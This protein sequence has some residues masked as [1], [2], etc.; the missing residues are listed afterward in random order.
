MNV[1]VIAEKATILV[2]D[3]KPYNLALMSGLF[4]EDYQVKIATCGEKALKIARSDSPP[5]LILLDIMMPVM[6]G[7][8]VCR[9]LK[10]DP[11]T[12]DI[13]VIFLTAK[14]ADEDEERGLVLGAID[15]I[16]KP[17]SLPIVM[18]RVKA[19]LTLKAASDLLRAQ[20][21]WNTAEQLAY[22]L[23][24]VSGHV[25]VSGLLELAEKIEIA[26]KARAD[27]QTVD[28]ENLIGQL[29]RKLPDELDQTAPRFDPEKLRAACAQ[30]EFLLIENDA[31]AIDVLDANAELF[32]AAFPKQ[33]H[34]IDNSI[35]SFDFGKAL[36][37]L[38]ATTQ[39]L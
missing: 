11:K 30:L 26:I 35:R 1:P 10:L 38:R 2:V 18:A 6:D 7:Y 32:D 25:G 29:N 36:I 8:E 28:L 14:T 33:F 4:K 27:G 12:R 3:D 34:E 9:Q 15:Y 37:G 19:H 16:S 21:D 20:N 31:G 17:I 39:G 22:T 5:D 24:R 13:P 23:K